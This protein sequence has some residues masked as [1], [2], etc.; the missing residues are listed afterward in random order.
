MHAPRA[1]SPQRGGMCR[2]ESSREAT[3]HVW[4][5]AEKRGGPRVGQDRGGDPVWVCSPGLQ[6]AEHESAWS[7]LVNL[8]EAAAHPRCLAKCTK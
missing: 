4:L 1:S 2:V 5:A 6:P 3:C 8:S 7:H